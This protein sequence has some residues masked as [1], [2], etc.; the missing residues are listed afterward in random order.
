M[1]T[2]EALSETVRGSIY[3]KLLLADLATGSLRDSIQ[4]T[5]MVFWMICITSLMLPGLLYIIYNAGA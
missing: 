4:A 3:Y 5:Q 1:H 2:F